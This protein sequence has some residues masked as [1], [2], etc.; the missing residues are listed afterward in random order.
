MDEARLF[1]VVC[2]NWTRSNGLK[3][4]HRKFHTNMWKN[5]F[6]VR[7]TELWNRLPREVVDSPST[8]IFKIHLDTY[9]CN[10]LYETYFSTGVP[11]RHCNSV[12]LCDSVKTVLV[13]VIP[14]SY[15]LTTQTHSSSVS[16]SVPVRQ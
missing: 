13:L 10:V 1:L 3:L 14:V 2:S 5:F 7:V 4:E 9:L 8:E 15:Q 16:K 6:M 12:I 11:S